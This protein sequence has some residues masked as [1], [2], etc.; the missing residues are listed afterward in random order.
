M[1]V[2]MSQ[3]FAAIYLSAFCR[4]LSKGPVMLRP[5]RFVIARAL[6]CSWTCILLT[7]VGCGKKIPYDLAPVS[8]KVVDAQGMPIKAA[9]IRTMTIF[10]VPVAPVKGRRDAARG[11]VDLE[12]G[13]FASVNTLKHNGACVGLNMVV[14]Q[15]EEKDRPKLS[16]VIPPEYQSEKT[17]PLQ[18]EVAPGRNNFEFKIKTKRSGSTRAAASRRLY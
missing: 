17:T 5:R 13:E 15:A 14:I 8:G 16:D 7:S 11:Q 1:R 9:S 10:F 4:V 2:F 18:V 12:T 3:I 6:A